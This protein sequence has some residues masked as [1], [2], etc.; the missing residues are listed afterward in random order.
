MAIQGGLLP[1]SHGKLQRT[2]NPGQATR[3][4]PEAGGSN[5][6]GAWNR[7]KLTGQK[8]QSRETGREGAYRQLLLFGSVSFSRDLREGDA[9]F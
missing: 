2:M 9:C 4:G 3:G 5:I 7:A 6:R 8:A 1:S